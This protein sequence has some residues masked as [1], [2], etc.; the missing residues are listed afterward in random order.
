MRRGSDESKLTKP[1]MMQLRVLKCRETG[2]TGPADLLDY[3][4]VTG[5]I[6]LVEQECPFDVVPDEGKEDF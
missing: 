3:N 5:R 2:D 1:T 6:E 4:R